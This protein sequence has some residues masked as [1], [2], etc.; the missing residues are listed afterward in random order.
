MDETQKAVTTP[1]TVYPID[2]EV[3]EAIQ[4]RNGS[5][6]SGAV[7]FIVRDWARISGFDETQRKSRRTRKSTEAQPA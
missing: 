5:S 3:I 6:F 1:V 4:N 2:R 7:R